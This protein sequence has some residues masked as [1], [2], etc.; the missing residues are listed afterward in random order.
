V[1][2]AADGARHEKAAEKAAAKKRQRELAIAADVKA[3][4]GKAAVESAIKKIQEDA[5][6][7]L[8]SFVSGG[9]E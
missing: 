4:A 2:I 6:Y 9:K 5:S 1:A 3:G 7:H 8:V